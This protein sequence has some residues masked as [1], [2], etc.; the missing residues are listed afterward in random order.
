MPDIV[1]A[2]DVA[3]DE[4]AF[5]R[6]LRLTAQDIIAIANRIIDRAPLARE[7]GEELRLF[8]RDV[9]RIG[10]ESRHIIRE[11][12]SMKEAVLN[13]MRGAAGNDRG[14]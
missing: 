9:Y 2:S 8:M 5:V 1:P 13:D 4:D 10:S 3:R 11:A 14:N 7:N 6:E 12:A